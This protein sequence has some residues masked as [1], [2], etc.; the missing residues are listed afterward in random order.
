M[1]VSNALLLLLIVVAHAV[2]FARL[3]RI[4][5]LIHLGQGRLPLDETPR[6]LRDLAVKGF[7]QSLVI[8]RPSGWGHF[9]IFWGFFI[10]TYGTLEG[11][12][13][14][15]TLFHF[16]F[17][18][19]GPIWVFMNTMQ[20]FFGLFVF[21]AIAI[22]V[23][24]RLIIK[25]RRLE[26]DFS[27]TLD[28]LLILGLIVALI[29]AFYTMRVVDPRPGFTPT[30][31]IIRS[32]ALG[33]NPP[34][35]EFSNNGTHET[36]FFV[37]EWIHNLVVLGFL[38]YIPFS[39][40]LHVVTA[41]PNLFFRQP[42]VRGQIENLDLEDENAESFGVNSVRDFKV[43][44]LLDVMACTEC[45]R[46]QE[47]CPAYATGKPLNP[48]AVVL[49]IKEYLFAIG[50]EMLKN[51]EAEPSKALYPDV[52][53]PEVLWACTS[54][55]ACEEACPVEIQP[56]T[57]LLKIRQGRV[58]ME[59]DFP[60]E[61]QNTL[62]NIEGQSNPWNLP[63]G[64]R[65]KWCEDL[66]VPKMAENPEV[67]YLYWVGCAGSYDQR[68]TKVSRALVKVMEAADIKFAILGEEEM[69]NGDSAKRI[70]NEMLAQMLMQQNIE[71]MNGYGVK[72]IITSCP[73]CFNTIKNEYPQMGGN[74]EVIHHAD[75]IDKL[76]GEGKITL[77]DRAETGNGA[78]NGNGTVTY[79]DSCYLARYNDVVQSPRNVLMAANGADNVVEMERRGYSGFCCGAGGGRMWMEERI[80]TQVNVDRSREAIAT[81][82]STVATA[83][84]FCMTMMTDGVNKEGA[85]VKVKDIA[86]IVAEHLPAK[87]PAADA[88]PADTPTADTIETKAADA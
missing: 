20:D 39:K 88:P 48:K 85:D 61:A 24:R 18:F 86:E 11:L 52:I 58:L 3:V 8:R 35:I 54:C 69:C 13:N 15:L 25:P 5:N 19:M 43:K 65:A 46:C 77:G 62:R 29:T 26:G 59:G 44:E 63:Q 75:L 28:A 41:L 36:V 53:T 78:G 1:T 56:M 38:M 31:D 71:T 49:D 12:I 57:K 76:V 16:D 80:G 87:A 4:W 32:V 55:R 84:P 37:A 6:R 83:C 42:K 70:G 27:H 68:Y 66:N 67:E 40:H 81:G 50:P 7:G 2:F 9:A 82:A 73:H 47:A 14:G 74:Y 51:P 23:Y 21:I 45:G 72:K 79:H 33:Y 60:E 30:S 10:L 17:S 64:E 34:P 22:A